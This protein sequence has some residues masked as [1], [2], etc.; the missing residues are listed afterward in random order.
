MISIHG[1]GRKARLKNKMKYHSQP[2]KKSNEIKTTIQ[3]EG[4]IT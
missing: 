3:T 2:K 1:T 4:E